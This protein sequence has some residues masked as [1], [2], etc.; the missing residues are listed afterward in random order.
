MKL[1]LKYKLRLN[2]LSL[3]K[4]P[5]SHIQ[6]APSKKEKKLLFIPITC[7]L[8]LHQR[9]VMLIKL[10]LDAY[11]TPSALTRQLVINC[12]LFLILSS[13][14]NPFMLLNS[15]AVIRTLC[16]KKPKFFH[17]SLK[18]LRI[19]PHPPFLSQ[20]LSLPILGTPFTSLKAWTTCLFL[21]F[22]VFHLFFFSPCI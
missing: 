15:I 6:H 20:A 9:W 19:C 5:K 2:K 16:R 21:G 7:F 18:Y 4:C 14:S 11:Q 13:V 10:Q 17:T 8:M 12:S 1:N 3:L 22:P